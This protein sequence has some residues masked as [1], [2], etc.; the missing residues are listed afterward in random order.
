MFTPPDNAS[1]IVTYAYLAEFFCAWY[2]GNPY[3]WF[4]ATNRALGPYK[5]CYWTMVFCN[6]VVPQALWSARVRSSAVVRA[7][8]RLRSANHAA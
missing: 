6:V 7:L 5:W 2:S 3:E 1:S 4:A 8:W